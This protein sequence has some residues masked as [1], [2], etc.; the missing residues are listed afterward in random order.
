MKRT[1]IISVGVLIIVILAAAWVYLLF[2]SQGNPSENFGNLG[3][4]PENDETIVITP[5]EEDEDEEVK[6]APDESPLQQLTTKSVVGYRSVEKPGGV[7]MV[8]FA[9]A[10]TGHVYEINLENMTERRISQTTILNAKEVVFSASGTEAMVL[11]GNGET[12]AFVGTI[13]DLEEE[14]ALRSIPASVVAMQ[15]G[16]AQEVVFLEEEEQRSVARALNLQTLSER[17]L[18]TIPFTS[19]RVVWGPSSTAN[20]YVYPKPAEALQGYLYSAQSGDVGY[21]GIEGFG[22]T[23]LNAGEY[24]LTSKVRDEKYQSSLVHKTTGEE[25]LF[26]PVLLPEKCLFLSGQS[27]EG[28]CAADLVTAEENLPDSWYKGEVRFSDQLWH[29]S[30]SSSS[31][32]LENNFEALSGRAIDVAS[33]QFGIGEKSLLLSN[34]LD[35]S[36]W[37]YEL[38]E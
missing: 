36:L 37:R 16:G 17:V 11:A 31:A 18:F 25:V 10:G 30:A 5:A 7:E 6:L 22:L 3:I 35:N 21:T 28:Y 13:N 32:A 27:G 34:K 12:S 1:I 14:M 20:H 29:I 2:F 8:V 33:M 26:A 38:Q 24:W 15:A 23:A 19:A 9:E 4:A